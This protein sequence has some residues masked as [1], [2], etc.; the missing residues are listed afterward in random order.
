MQLLP[1][2]FIKY[3]NAYN[4]HIRGEHAFIFKVMNGNSVWFEVFKKKSTKREVTAKFNTGLIRHIP[5]QE[6]YPGNESFGKWAWCAFTEEKALKYFNGLE[7]LKGDLKAFY[8]FRNPN[9]TVQVY[10]IHD[11][12]GVIKSGE[13]SR[14]VRI[15]SLTNDENTQALAKKSFEST[16]SPGTTIDTYKIKV[17]WLREELKFGRTTEAVEEIEEEINNEEDEEDNAKS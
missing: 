5:I 8:E 14:V 12:N 13:L 3:G 1:E 2:N 10:E 7:N 11:E 4:L 16:L 6:L 15:I 17:V 9:P